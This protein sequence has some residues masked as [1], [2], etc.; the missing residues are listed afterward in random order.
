M[1]D[2]L[3]KH[4]PRIRLK[5]ATDIDGLPW[6]FQRILQGQSVMTVANMPI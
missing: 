1:D 4:D 6:H 2:H 3:R 5:L